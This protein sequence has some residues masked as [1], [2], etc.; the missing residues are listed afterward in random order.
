MSAPKCS[1]DDN[2]LELREQQSLNVQEL[3]QKLALFAA[4][5]NCNAVAHFSIDYCLIVLK[6]RKPVFEGVAGEI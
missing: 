5:C 6:F 4:Y 2:F 3:N 1:L